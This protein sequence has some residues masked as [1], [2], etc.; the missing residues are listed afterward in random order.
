MALQGSLQNDR[1]RLKSIGVPIWHP[2]SENTMPEIVDPNLPRTA[3][4][5]WRNEIINDGSVTLGHDHLKLLDTIR[6]KLAPMGDN[7]PKDLL[8]Q[9]FE[10]LTKSARRCAYDLRHA[11]DDLSSYVGPDHYVDFSQR[12][13]QWLEIFAPDGI[14]NYRLDLHREI[15][16][17]ESQVRRLT[18][19]CKANGIDDPIF[20]ERPF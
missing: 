2:Q 19:L 16:M 13:N 5:E 15:T 3:V 12:A 8:A 4:S 10:I 17:L 6:F 1:H 7:D 11:A 9:H 20:S 14:K 18:D